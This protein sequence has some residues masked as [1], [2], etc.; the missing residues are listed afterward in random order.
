MATGSRSSS[1]FCLTMRY[2]P[3]AESRSPKLERNPKSE[4]DLISSCQ[5]ARDGE[6]LDFVMRSSNCADSASGLV[7]LLI[8]GNALQN[9]SGDVVRRHAFTLRREIRDDAMSEDRQGRRLDV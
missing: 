1:M 9:S 5:D 2:R 8:F 7:Q 6:R 4:G 3:K